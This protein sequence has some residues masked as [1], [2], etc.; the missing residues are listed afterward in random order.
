MPPDSVAAPTCAQ[1][2]LHDGKSGRRPVSA[3]ITTAFIQDDAE[4]ART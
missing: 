3:I 2:A 4:A 1:R